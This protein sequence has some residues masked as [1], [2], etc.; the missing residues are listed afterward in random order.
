MSL[1]NILV[2]IFVLL[3][4]FLL[5]VFW[6]NNHKVAHFASILR[7]YLPYILPCFFLFFWFFI[8]F[9]YKFPVTGD[10][11]NF[12]IPQGR[13]AFQGMI[14][15]KDFPSSY[16]PLYPYVL[17]FIDL[18]WT[19]DLSIGLF[20]T[21]SL[22]LLSVVLFN[23]IKNNN[24]FLFIMIVGLCNSVILLL[25]VGYQQDEIFVLLLIFLSLFSLTKKKYFLT[26]FLIGASVLL[27]KITLIIFWIP[28]FLLSSK[29]KNYLFGLMVSFIPVMIFFLIAGF[30]PM[31][32]LG[33]ESLAIV[34][35]SLITLSRFLPFIY[36]L[37]NSYPYLIYVGNML[38]LGIISI[39]VITNKREIGYDLYYQFG[40]LAVFWLIFVLLS[41]KALTSYRIL[42][43][44]F[45]PFIV[46]V[47][48]SKSPTLP[49]LFVIYSSLVSVHVMFFEDWAKITRKYIDLAS[50]P[51][52]NLH[53]FIIL[54][55]IE[56]SIVLLEILWVYLSLRII[57]PSKSLLNS[58]NEN[59]SLE[60]L[61]SIIVNQL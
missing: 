5:L 54:S 58:Q 40:M 25:G 32:M 33:Q 28:F 45:I 55:A 10:V 9:I 19:N 61:P 15:N 17:G 34:P 38:V 43:I 46:E 48:R 51:A 6:L 47:F 59:S 24:K 13:L 18:F 57:F 26:G 35:P 29:K 41:F 4:N 23:I 52:A 20:F 37:L 2:I 8:F 31:K 7:I 39:F 1:Q 56:V 14:P 21:L 60:G 53:Q 49:I 27:S 44:V 11:V 50:I 16:M 22:C 30:S 3:C 36:N 12:F 42:V